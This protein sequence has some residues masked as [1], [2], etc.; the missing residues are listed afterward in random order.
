[1]TMT[2]VNLKMTGYQGHELI[3]HAH[4]SLPTATVEADRGS[5]SGNE[6]VTGWSQ[7]GREFSTLGKVI[8]IVSETYALWQKKK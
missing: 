3:T 2:W 4:P 7:L 6:S 5:L 1:M 8:N